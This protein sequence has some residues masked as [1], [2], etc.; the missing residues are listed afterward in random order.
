M[1][2]HFA[3]CFT[4]TNRLGA[5]CLFFSFKR[6]VNNVQVWTVSL[7]L[8]I[9]NSPAVSDTRNGGSN[10]SF[11]TS[12][13]IAGIVLWALGFLIEAIADQQKVGVKQ[14]HGYALI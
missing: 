12:R 4:R 1:I 6:V 11:G 13:D 10:P 8:V 5:I 14:S 7:P 9:L 3:F 2:S